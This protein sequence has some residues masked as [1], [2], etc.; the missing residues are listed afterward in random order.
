[1]QTSGVKVR[2]GRSKFCISSGATHVMRKKISD[3]ITIKAYC[4]AS[5]VHTVDMSHYN[6]AVPLYVY[7]L[8]VRLQYSM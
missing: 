1:M 2:P 4:Q 5:M 7:I 6:L 3:T 8:L